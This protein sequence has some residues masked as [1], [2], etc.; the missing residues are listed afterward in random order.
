MNKLYKDGNRTVI[1]VDDTEESLLSA[2]TRLIEESGLSPEIIPGLKPLDTI[3][4]TKTPI[5][6]EPAIEIHTAA[7]A[8]TKEIITRTQKLE[9]IDSY[10]NTIAINDMSHNIGLMKY[11]MF[12]KVATN[13]EVDQLYDTVIN[14]TKQ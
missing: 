3:T 7:P 12:K 13:S 10:I 9:V 14:Q 6:N 1:V 2:V 11:D 8:P 5:I 4:E